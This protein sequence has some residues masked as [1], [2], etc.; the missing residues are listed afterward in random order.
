MICPAIRSNHLCATYPLLTVSIMR[1]GYLF[2]RFTRARDAPPRRFWRGDCWPKL[3]ETLQFPFKCWILFVVAGSS[4]LHLNRIAAGKK[5]RRSNPRIC[6]WGKRRGLAPRKRPPRTYKQPSRRHACHLA[7]F[8]RS[9]GDQP[10][11][12]PSE[13]CSAK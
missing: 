3:Y 1:C 4:R 8:H 7:S 9:L 13:H 5:R 11:A 6:L 2:Y 10:T 12:A